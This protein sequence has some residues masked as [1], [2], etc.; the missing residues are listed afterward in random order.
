M[1]CY[2]YTFPILGFDN[3][4]KLLIEKGSDLNAIGE[5]GTKMIFSGFITLFKFTHSFF[6]YNH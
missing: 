6:L 3:A 2:K 4:T 5:Y 1:I